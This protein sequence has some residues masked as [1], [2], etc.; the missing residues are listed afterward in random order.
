MKFLHTSDLH[1][2]K[3]V[4]EFSMIE[5]QEYILAQIKAIAMSEKVD[6]VI[7]AGDIYDRSI[8]STEAVELLDRFLTELLAEKIQVIMIS[9]NHDSPER[10]SFADK[11]LEKQGLY[12][13][14]SIEGNI[15]QVTLQDEWGDVTFVCI[16]FVKPALVG[17]KTSAEAVEKLLLEY[18]KQAKN[19]DRKVLVTHFFVTGDN[20]EAPELSESESTVNVGGL[21]NVPSSLF[22]DFDYVALGHIHKSQKIGE[23]PVYYVGAPLKYSFSEARGMKYV[24]LVTMAVK[25][26]VE[27]EKRELRPLHE[28]RVI[29]GKLADLMA[30]QVVET[31]DRKDYIQAILTDDIELIDPIGTLRSV[32]PNIMQIVMEKNR[33]SN[34]EKNEINIVIEQKS[35]EELFGDFYKMLKEEPLDEVRE[36]IVREVAMTARKEEKGNKA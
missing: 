21:D 28:M 32:Y 2:G 7:I 5:D 26:D 31:V 36:E 15:K 12:I 6:A 25:G 4:N 20:G 23:R 24:N 11:I 18:K 27:V 35:T 13:S 34:G 16:P 1:I 10:V 9:G 17:V 22:K 14:G 30:P 19:Q 8:P 3:I 29:K 33:I